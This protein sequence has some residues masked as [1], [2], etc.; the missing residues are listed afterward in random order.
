MLIFEAVGTLVFVALTVF[1]YKNDNRNIMLAASI[2]LL[3]TL[4]GPDFV[5]GFLNGYNA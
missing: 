3:A 5:G 2:C 4:A 1:G